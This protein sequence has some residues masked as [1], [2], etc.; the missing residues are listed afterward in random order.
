MILPLWWQWGQLKGNHQKLAKNTTNPICQ[1]S[2]D[3]S[4]IICN[5]SSLDKLTLVKIFIRDK[6]SLGCETTLTE[7]IRTY[8]QNYNSTPCV[9][10]TSYSSKYTLYR[11]KFSMS[12]CNYYSF[13]CNFLF[14]VKISEWTHHQVYWIYRREL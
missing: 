3:T 4:T 7:H 2:S 8:W 11:A 6:I 13:L 5:D 9:Q 10:K 1:T 12:N 14:K